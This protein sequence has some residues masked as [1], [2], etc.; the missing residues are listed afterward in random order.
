[1]KIGILGSGPVGQKLGDAFVVTGHE[2]MIGTRNPAKVQPW[3]SK[4]SQAKALSGNFEQAA[5]FGDMVV[6]ATLWEGTQGA[7][8]AA[9]AE[10]L[11][12]KVTI[13][14]TNPLDFSTGKPRLAIGFNNSGGE[15]VQRLLPN[16]RVVKA[17]NIIGNADMYQPKFPGGPPTMFICGNDVEAKGQVS[18]ILDSFGWEI[19]DVGDIESSRLLESL[20]M[21]W[22]AY[23]VKTGTG[24][25]AFKLLKR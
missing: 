4:H 1:M 16:A 3:V 6:L 17:F 7:I 12:G 11:S 18:K 22:I 14:V 2:V 21:L 23:Y 8:E 13:D 10:N 5:K 15:T 20:A 9:G 19:V 24:N 25:H